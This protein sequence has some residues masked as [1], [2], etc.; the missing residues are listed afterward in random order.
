MA[1]T[2][3]PAMA[4]ELFLG[5]SLEA[6]GFTTCVFELKGDDNVG[7]LPGTMP[8]EISAGYLGAPILAPF[9]LTCETVWPCLQMQRGSAFITGINAGDMT[10]GTVDYYAFY[11]DNDELVWYRGSGPFGIPVVK[12]DNAELGSGATNVQVDDMC[13]FRV[14]GHVGMI[15]DPG[16]IHMTIDA[17]SEDSIDVP[18]LT[19]LLPP[20]AT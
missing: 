13:P 3:S 5:N 11:T 1:G 2:F 12:H 9:G 20:V 7:N 16:P 4:N 15:V 18:L 6:A 19:C 10:P 14:V 17:L 8:T